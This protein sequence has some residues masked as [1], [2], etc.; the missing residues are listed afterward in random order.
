MKKLVFILISLFF[1]STYAQ[2]KKLWAKSILNEK[3]PTL[4]V[5]KW[6]SD[7]PA[8]EAKFVLIDF[9]ATWCGPCRKAIPDLN[10]FQKEFKD[11]L[12][13]IGISDEVASKVKKQ[14]EP[15]IDY[16]NAIDRKQRL[17]NALEVRGIPHC[18]I[19]DPSGIVRWEG[20]PFLKGHELTSQVIKNIIK[21]HQ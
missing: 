14:K 21:K 1:I 9:W 15:T 19:I 18:I 10:S 11:D 3:A 16:Y 8:I 5:E 4:I 2:E 6:L 17:K 20:F 13:V 12:I 7:K